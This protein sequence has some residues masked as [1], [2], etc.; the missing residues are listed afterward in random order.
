MMTWAVTPVLAW[1][2]VAAMPVRLSLPAGMLMLSVLPSS[3]VR[4]RSKVWPLLIALVLV[5]A[6]SE[7]RRYYFV[8]IAL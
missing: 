5:L 4:V 2:M 3:C 6:L 7:E 1:L 8:V